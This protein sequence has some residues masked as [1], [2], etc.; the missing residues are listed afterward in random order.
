[1]RPVTAKLQRHPILSSN[2]PMMGTP[3]ADENLAAE[4]N[5]EVAKLRS[6]GGNQR[7]MALAFAGKVGASPTPSR[8]RAANRPPM[9]GE[10]AAAKDAMLHKK[11][12]TR[13]TRRIPNLS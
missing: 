2:R 9:L 5:S 7:P 13:P 3:M 4:S 6:W 11:V 12:L 1:M 10:I 8:K